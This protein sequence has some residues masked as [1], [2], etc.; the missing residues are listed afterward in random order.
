M[1]VPGVVMMS[2]CGRTPVDEGAC[3]SGCGRALGYQR[4]K[5]CGCGSDCV[6]ELEYVGV[7]GCCRG[8]GW[9]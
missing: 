1:T 7:G 6:G 9:G 2:S 4:V 3:G 8:C 5:A